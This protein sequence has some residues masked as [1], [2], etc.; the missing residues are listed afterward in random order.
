MMKNGELRIV[1]VLLA[2][3]LTIGILFGGYSVYKVYGV[4]KPVETKLSALPAVS[5]VSIDKNKKVYEIK[6]QLGAV[7][8]LQSAYTE[9]E[10]ALNRYFKVNDYQLQIIDN[11]NE[12]LELFYLQIQPAVQQTAA[13]SE[14]VWLDAYLDEK[15]SQTGLTYNLM[16]DEKNIYIQIMDSPYYLYEVVVR[17]DVSSTL[18]DEP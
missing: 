12:K 1:V 15:C 17:P 5:S 6:L 7:E 4:E 11:R 13:K 2:M 16:I 18:P 8:N 14:F 9:I 10:N 3:I